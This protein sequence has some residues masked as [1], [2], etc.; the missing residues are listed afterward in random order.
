MGRDGSGVRPISE[1]SIE[2]TFTYRGARCRERIKLQPTPANL[3]RAE[4]HR[5][6]ILD[7]IERG[8]FDYSVTFPDSPRRLLFVERKGEALTV[9]SYL[10]T[11]L[12]RQQDR[13]KVSTFDGYRKVVQHKL[14]PAFGQT[15]LSELK[16]PLLREWFDTQKVSNKR[17]ANIQSVLRAAL[18]D[19]VMDELIESN[20]LYGWRYARRDTLKDEDDVDPFTPDEQHAILSALHGQAKHLVQFALW[21]GLRTSELVALNWGDIDWNR[22]CVVVSRAIT[23]KAKG[24]AETT[25]TRAGKREVK[26][27]SPALSALSDQKQFTYLKGQEIFQDPRTLERWAGDQPIREGMWKRA[28]QIAKVRYRRPY[29]TRHTY[30]SMMLTAGES[31]MWVAQQM[32]HADWGMIRRVYGRFIHDAQPEAGCK[33]EALFQPNDSIKPAI[34]N[35]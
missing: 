26:L 10:T 15:I 2:I 30:A 1:T 4:R 8:T 14:I 5:A 18:Q 21:T 20:P 24:Q 12:K 35:N 32:G 34:N 33:A 19:A 31:P 23:Q 9:E 3:K 27:L 22:K 7:A 13:L 6:A 11:W 17:L 29:Q 16:R 28:L 25:K